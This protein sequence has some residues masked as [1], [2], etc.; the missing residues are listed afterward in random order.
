MINFRYLEKN[1][2]KLKK[3]KLIVHIYLKAKNI[4]QYLPRK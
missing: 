2:K 3:F 1:K 4:F